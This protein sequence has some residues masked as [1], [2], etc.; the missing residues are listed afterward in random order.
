MT[1]PSSASSVF[2][3]VSSELG[4]DEGTEP[5]KRSLMPL[6]PSNVNQFEFVKREL[7]YKDMDT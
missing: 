6:S 2:R 7:L 4:D 1:L 5:D 3:E